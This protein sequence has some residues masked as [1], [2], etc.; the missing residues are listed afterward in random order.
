MATFIDFFCAIAS[1]ALI[2]L[3]VL[4]TSYVVTKSMSKDNLEAPH[5]P[6]KTH[7]MPNGDI[8]YASSKSTN[9]GIFCF[10]GDV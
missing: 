5:N 1:I 6:I 9:A 4:G 7:V 3:F 10:R 8:C 2:V